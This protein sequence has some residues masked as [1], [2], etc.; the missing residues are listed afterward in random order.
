MSLLPDAGLETKPKRVPG[1]K[2]PWDRGRILMIIG[3]VMLLLLSI[4]QGITKFGLPRWFD[5]VVRVT[6][7]LVLVAGFALR[8]KLKREHRMAARERAEAAK[9][10]SPRAPG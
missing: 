4:A 8:M 5:I 10:S 2:Q 6:G 7:Y 1:W 9:G 3:C